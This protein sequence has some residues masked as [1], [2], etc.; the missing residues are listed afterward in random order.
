VIERK[1]GGG[2]SG[3]DIIMSICYCDSMQTQ[4]VRTTVYL[5]RNLVEMAKIEAVS[6]KTRLTRLVES[7][8]KKELGIKPRKK[9]VSLGKYHLGQYKFKRADAY[10]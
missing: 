10:E 4:M 3:I 1:G 9:G 8:L 2:L 6:R 7:G 5:P